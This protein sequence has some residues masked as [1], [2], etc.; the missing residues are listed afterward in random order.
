MTSDTF[1]F[2][3]LVLK[4]QSRLIV[5]CQNPISRLSK[6]G[7]QTNRWTNAWP[8][9]GLKK[10]KKKNLQ[11]LSGHTALI[12]YQILSLSRAAIRGSGSASAAPIP[13]APFT[14]PPPPYPL[15]SSLH[16]CSLTAQPDRH[17]ISHPV[18]CVPFHFKSSQQ[19]LKE[20]LNPPQQTHV[21]RQTHTCL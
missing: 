3:A 17:V 1:Q 12:A 7:E 5:C 18:T 19:G 20:G 8:T 11:I 21:D 15:F 4:H 2:A 13:S 16:P 9:W 14:P 6:A 10:K